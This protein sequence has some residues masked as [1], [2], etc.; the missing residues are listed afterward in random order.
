MKGIDFSQARIKYNEQYKNQSILTKSLC[1][2]DGKFIEN[3]SIKDVH[4]EP[5]EEFYKWQFIYSLVSAELIPSRDYIGAEIYFPKGN[6]HS[7]PIKIDSVIFSDIKWIDYY[8]KYRENP[9]DVDSLQKVR[10]LAVGVIEYKRNDKSIEQVF[11]S[12]IRAAI[13]EPDSP[14][15]LGIYYDTGRLFL[16]K[17]IGDEI[18][19]FDNNKSFPT[20]QRVLER[21]QLEITD[22]YSAIPSLDNISKIINKKYTSDRSNMKIEDLDVVYT[23]HD[24]NMKIALNSIM[25]VLDS[26][27]LSNQEGYMHLIQLIAMKIYD[28]KQ[29]EKHGGSLQFYINDDEVYSGNMNSHSVQ[30]FVSRMKALYQE[31]KAY[32][33]NILGENKILWTQER[34]I[35]VANEIVK[36]FQNYSFVKS[37]NNDLYQLIFYNFATKFQRDEKAQFLTPLQIID[38]IVKI[39]NPKSGET[40]CDPCCG[41]ADFLSQSYVNAEMK[42]DDCKL[43]GFDNDYNMTVLAQ[44]NMLLNGDGNAVIKYVPEYGTINQKLTINQEVVTLDTSIHANGNWDNWYDETEL[45]KYDVVLTNPP[46]GKNRSLDLS[47]KNDVEVAKLYEL[48]SLYTETN[49]KAGLDKGVVF[50]ENAVHSVKE[51]TGRFAI[52]LSNAIMS[53]NTWLFVRQWL[54]KKI[55]IVALFDL[56]ANVFAETGVNTTI[57]VG[58]KPTE[59]R[60]KELIDDDYSVFTRDIINVGYTK[61][62]SKRTVKFDPDYA[63]NPETFET[64]TN[65]KGESV[66]NEDFSK[67]IYEFKEWCISQETEIKELFLE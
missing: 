4:G 59:K 5:N 32:Y 65:E 53:N 42:L 40:I 55:R 28:E 1:T 7:Q 22:P 19:R 15:V 17:R 47:N 11:S 37:S 35:K 13:K 45:L 57:I 31:A 9:K 60:L 44:L 49:P 8:R 50:L 29:R 52:V 33:K 54:M 38:F 67:I 36:E 66:L 10:E 34:H 18:T 3:I 24:D 48:Y 51:K 23:I 43:Y 27:S 39:V 63:L 56:P 25:R 64:I 21:F 41:I 61:R 12:Q 30:K 62:T 20:S 26:V 58:Y 46:F 16:F 6:V 14:F 2:V